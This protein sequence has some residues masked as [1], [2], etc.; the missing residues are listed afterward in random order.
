[1]PSVH[2]DNEFGKCLM[3]KSYKKINR[4]SCS[5]LMLPLNGLLIYLM[6]VVFIR[7]FGVC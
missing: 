1:M 4:L 2:W 7:A 6:A 3:Y 5:D